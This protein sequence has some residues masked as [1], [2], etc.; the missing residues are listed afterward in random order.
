MIEPTDGAALRRNGRGRG[1]S[2]GNRSHSCGGRAPSRQ[3]RRS[4]QDRHRPVGEIFTLI[5]RQRPLRGEPVGEAPHAEPILVTPDGERTMT[6]SRR[7]ANEHARSRRRYHR[8]LKYA[9]SEAILSTE[10]QPRAFRKR[11]GSRE[12][13]HDRLAHPVRPFCGE[14]HRNPSTI[15]RAA[16]ICCSPMSANC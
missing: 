10:S 16:S 1:V 2:G 15:S 4:W 3:G 14:R 12:R 13:R 9:L 6:P 11:R 5:C 8:R 7:A